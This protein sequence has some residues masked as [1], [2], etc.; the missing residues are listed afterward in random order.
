MSL[1]D[2]MTEV[3]D[4]LRMDPGY[5]VAW[6]ANIAMAFVDEHALAEDKADIHGIANRAAVRFLRLLT[7]ECADET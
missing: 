2:A 4:T 7:R 1:K 6:E 3:T 5:W